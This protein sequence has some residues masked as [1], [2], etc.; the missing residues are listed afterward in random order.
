MKTV[1]LSALIT[2]LATKALN[3]NHEFDLKTSAMLLKKMAIVACDEV[4]TLSTAVKEKL[5]D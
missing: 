5:N 3:E 1:I 4:Q 2:F